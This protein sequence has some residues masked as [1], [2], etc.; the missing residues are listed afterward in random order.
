M[1]LSSSESEED[2]LDAD[3][4]DPSGCIL[5][6]CLTLSSLSSESE[7]DDDVVWSLLNIPVIFYIK[8]TYTGSFPKF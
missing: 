5:G 2:E 7:L 1:S 3:L 8:V 4:T 6:I